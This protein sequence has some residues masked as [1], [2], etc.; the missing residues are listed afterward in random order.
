[1][2]HGY[3]IFSKITFSSSSYKILELK[4][5]AVLVVWIKEPA[6][7]CDWKS[8]KNLSKKPPVLVLQKPSK[9]H[10]FSQ[11]KVPKNQQFYS[12][13]VDGFFEIF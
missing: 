12:R 5:A 3:F 4:E 1:V 8:S 10:Q 6:V 11:E 2:L 13:L 7:P 9:N